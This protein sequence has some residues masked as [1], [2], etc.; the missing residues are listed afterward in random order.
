[1]GSL[2]DEFLRPRE[3]DTDLDDLNAFLTKYVCDNKLHSGALCTEEGSIIASTESWNENQ[4]N[5]AAII[6]QIFEFAPTT[7]LLPFEIT[8]RSEYKFTI[9]NKQ[10][11]KHIVGIKSGHG[12]F[13]AIVLAD[14]SILFVAISQS[15]FTVP[16]A[17]SISYAMAEFLEKN[18]GRG[19][20]TKSARKV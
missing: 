8:P 7:Q 20:R 1:M 18:L 17:I 11:E 2:R 4:K 9:V 3:G 16:R 6:A 12:G 19:K 5:V 13:V 14:G 15:S 10:P